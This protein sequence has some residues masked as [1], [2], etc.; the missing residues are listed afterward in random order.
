MHC[1]CTNTTD[2]PSL[3]PAVPRHSRELPRGVVHR[4][5]AGTRAAVVAVVDAGGPDSAGQRPARLPRFR[6]G[7][8][9]H[10]RLRGHVYSQGMLGLP[11]YDLL[12]LDFRIVFFKCDFLGVSDREERFFNLKNPLIFSF[13]ISFYTTNPIH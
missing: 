7:R 4:R 6:D 13:R 1:P 3:P 10:H 8:H 11:V 2:P 5:G 9:R 12:L